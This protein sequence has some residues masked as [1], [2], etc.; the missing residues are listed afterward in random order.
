MLVQPGSFRTPFA[1]A[2]ARPAKASPER[3]GNGFVSPPY[4]DTP[5]DKNLQRIASLMD[6]GVGDPAKAARA[7]VDVAMGEGLGKGMEGY[8]RLPL[9]TD[10]LGVWKAKTKEIAENLG[11]VETIAATT[12]VDADASRAGTFLD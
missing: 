5:T 9:G 12:N 1:A 2:A 7:I 10:T 8:L 3:G 4:F 11:A 6:Q